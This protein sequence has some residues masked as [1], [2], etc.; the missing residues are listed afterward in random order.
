MALAAHT[1]PD[2]GVPTAQNLDAWLERLRS[3][4]FPVL[5]RTA[6][7]IAGL[8]AKGE[9]ASVAEIA[10]AILLD[11]L[12]TLKVLQIANS[13]RRGRFGSEITTMEHA[14]MMLGLPPFFA[15]FRNLGVVEDELSEQPQALQH[16]LS[17][18]SRSHHAAVQAGDWAVWHKD[19]KAE[20]IYIAALLQGWLEP[21]LW[22]RAPDAAAECERRARN[23]AMPLAAAQAEVLGVAPQ[24]LQ[25]ALAQ[26]LH[27]PELLLDLMG[28]VDPDVRTRAYGVNLAACV[29]R[30]SEQDWHGGQLAA[31]V[32]SASAFLHLPVDAVSSM[33]HRSAVAA[34]RHWEWYGVAPAA[35]RLPLLPP[36]AA[37]P[38]PEADDVCLMPQHAKLENCLAEIAE[39]L[40]ASMN[41]HD[42]MALVLK[43]MHDGIGLNRVVF[44]LLNADR[45]KVRTKYVLGAE[46]GS[47]LRNFEFDMK[48]PHLFA[49]LMEKMQGVWLN[50]SNR[51]KLDPLI[52]AEIRALTGDGEFFAMSVF[53]RDKAVGFFY[54]DRGNG[55][56][57]LDERSYHHFKQLCMRAAQGLGHL[58]QS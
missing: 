4:D 31:D 47:P 55:G 21:L 24:E 16:L 54:A 27:L 3:D 49:R 9:K 15:R 48:V 6:K 23:G 36:A 45:S 19:M 26:A 52:P 25:S 39:H 14:V 17:L 43:G 18:L 12:A 30:H 41:L 20:E 22:L 13:L 51:A 2:A 32:E 40:D 38:P 42:M 5:R 44:A 50:G 8:A 34:A 28:T 10:D 1:D 11:P 29:A 57:A 33:M 56:C 58:A 46:A 7:E 35:A 37:E 53:V